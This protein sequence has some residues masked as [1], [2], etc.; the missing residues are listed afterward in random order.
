MVGF[1]RFALNLKIMAE[2]YS[3]LEE[4]KKRPTFLIALLVLTSISLFSLLFQSVVPMITGPKIPT[5]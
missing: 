3:N 1:S 4:K 5:S 2:N